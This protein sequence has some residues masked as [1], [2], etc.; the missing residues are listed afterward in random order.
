MKALD[1]ITIVELTPVTASGQW[2]AKAT[3]GTPVHTG[4]TLIKDGHDVLA[5]ALRWRSDGAAWVWAPM[6]DAG[7]GRFVGSFTPLEL[8]H[9]Q[10]QVVA[11]TDRLAGW[12][13]DLA[14]RA[15]AGQ[16]LEV[17]FDIG[18]QLLEDL[19]ACPAQGSPLDHETDG[20]PRVQETIVQL[21][22][23]SCSRA[24]RLEAAL[25]Q[26]VAA[27]ASGVVASWDQT[28]SAKL[29]VW[30]DRHRAE[31]SAWY[32][33]FPRSY[34][35]FRGVMGELD[36]VAALG[37]DV[38][39]LPPIHPI[40]TSHRKG[41]G[42]ALVA[43]D[44]DP[45]SP[46]AIGGLDGG[47]CAIHPELGTEAEFVALVQAASTKGIEVA[48]DY[49]LQCSPDHPWVSE[50]PEWFHRRPD[51]SI[52]FA[53]NPPKQYQDIYPINFWPELE[54][55]RRALW[56]AC[57][58]IFEH[59]IERGV[60]IFRVD[61]PHT[62]PLAFWAWVIAAVR[63]R[64]PE[65]LFLAEAFTAPAMMA[66]LGE[67]GFSQSY[68]YFTW[69]ASGAELTQYLTELTAS[70]SRQQMRPNFWP[71]TPDILEGV[72]RNGP[73]SAFALRVVLAGT[74]VPSYGIYSGYELGENQPQSPDNTEYLH[75]EKY[76]T[77]RRDFSGEGTLNALITT[78]NAWRGAHR[79]LQRLE[80]LVFHGS[81]N[82][83][84]LVYSRRW[85]ED[86]VLCVVNL[87]PHQA[88][89]ATLSLDLGALGLAGGDAD[90]DG[91]DGS[92]TRLRV[93]DALS[94]QVFQWQ[95]AHPWVRLDP[96]QGPAHLLHVRLG[97]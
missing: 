89:A 21:R 1:H 63:R 51:G 82:D 86:V 69:R 31:F 25:N 47:H 37:F 16:D 9:H 64:H 40:G 79:A 88:Q 73:I 12:R 49:A 55:D 28:R 90:G 26:E 94:D 36:R 91:G 13:R 34:G 42:N 59:W 85:D 81:D 7:Q 57:L 43:Q 56:H 74:L 20:W 60:A 83:A 6:H 15:Q 18:A 14:K 76:Q 3:V 10:V 48:L 93:E 41:P 44:G 2:P 52:R 50:H 30:V 92:Q 35:G 84:V 8:G 33:L 45:G 22:S 78:L 80:G 68:T 71:N 96:A 95:G 29:E 72:L 61:N 97:W 19:A 67:V 65:V 58:E 46:W 75:S 77:V 39:Y 70:P 66:R 87:D 53:E 17:E 38:L 23:R 27:A 4:A 62:K 5:A 54:A 11:W 32:E 24:V